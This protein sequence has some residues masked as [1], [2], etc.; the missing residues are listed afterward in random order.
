MHQTYEILRYSP[1]IDVKKQCNNHAN[2]VNEQNYDEITSTG[3]FLSEMSDISATDDDILGT[4]ENLHQQKSMSMEFNAIFGSTTE[5]S[6]KKMA[7]PSQPFNENALEKT[8]MI[9]DL[10]PKTQ[11][12]DDRKNRLKIPS[13][14]TFS[15]KFLHLSD[16]FINSKLCETIGKRSFNAMHSNDSDCNP[17]YER[18]DDEDEGGVFRLKNSL[19]NIEPKT[20][21]ALV[22]PTN[23][24]SDAL[25]N[26]QDCHHTFSYRTASRSTTCFLCSKK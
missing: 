7:V 9:K 5:N 15:K 10:S 6:D 19:K 14:M 25:I 17:I 22:T 24:K 23:S 18:I 2:D 21:G 11:T 3:S 16:N 13:P 20:D 12:S 26:A 1:S 8:F 4:N